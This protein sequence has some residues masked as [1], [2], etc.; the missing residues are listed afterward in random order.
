MGGGVTGQSGEYII[1]ILTASFLESSWK[2]DSL[3]LNSTINK[4]FMCSLYITSKTIK[5]IHVKH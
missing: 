1:V 4:L 5:Q 3:N 2:Y